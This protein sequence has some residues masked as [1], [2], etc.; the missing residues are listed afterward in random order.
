MNNES[1]VFGGITSPEPVLLVKLADDNGINVIG[2]SVGHDL[3]GILDKNSQ[4]TYSLNDFYE[5]ALDDYTKGE[6]RYPFH[7]LQ[8]GRHQIKVQAWD[9]ANNPAE[10]YTEFLVVT[11]AEVALK[12]V[13]NYPN[14]FTTSTC[15]MFEHN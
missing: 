15:F 4:N 11:S 12:H 9:I 14:P 1:F 13:L 3:A 10:G 6:V 5:S 2:N 8:E 7:S